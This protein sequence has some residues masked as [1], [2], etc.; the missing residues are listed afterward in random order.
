MSQSWISVSLGFF[1]LGSGLSV[2]QQKTEAVL[3]AREIFYKAN[4]KQPATVS[5]PGQKAAPAAP[6]R[7]TPPPQKATPPAAPAEARKTDP[8]PPRP[9]LQCQCRWSRIRRWGC[10]TASSE[11]GTRTV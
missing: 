11:I 2:A 5:A 4:T 6:A 7:T 9:P 3:N 10:D 1:L 8:R